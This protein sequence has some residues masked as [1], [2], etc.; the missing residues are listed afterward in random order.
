MGTG[1]VRDGFGDEVS[2]RFDLTGL[3]LLL[4]LNAS[5]RVGI[6][7]IL[8]SSHLIVVVVVVG[9]WWFFDEQLTE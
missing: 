1:S 2:W 6:R 8:V 7:G 5:T 9:F 4:L 3:Q